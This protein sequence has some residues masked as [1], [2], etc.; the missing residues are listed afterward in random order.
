MLASTP[1]W[2]MVAQLMER[3][4]VPFRS[5][6]WR[7]GLLVGDRVDQAG[8]RAIAQQLLDTC[9]HL[10]AFTKAYKVGLHTV[11]DVL[12]PSSIRY[13]TDIF[14]NTPI[15]NIVSEASFAASH[16]RR[17]SAHGNEP[18]PST[19]T[20]NHVLATAK[21]DLD[22]F[23]D[24]RRLVEEHHSCGEGWRNPQIPKHSV[25]VEWGS[26]LSCV[27]YIRV[28]GFLVPDLPRHA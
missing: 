4:I 12:A 22:L 7:L 25:A 3:F 24:R 18:V 8:K 19:V 26:Y 6:P 27:I 14:C 17:Q 23:H 15:S 16:V 2:M 9:D 1:M 11:E 13:T 5:W 21:T 10:D 28:P 20:A